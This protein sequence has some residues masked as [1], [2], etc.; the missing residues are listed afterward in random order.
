MNDACPLLLGMGDNLA[1][2]LV[3]DVAHPAPL[4]ALT[5]AH[6]ADLPGPLQ[7]L[8]SGIET[9]AAEPLGAAIAEEPRP[10]PHEMHHGRYLPA[11]VYSHDGLTPAGLCPSHPDPPLPTPPPPLT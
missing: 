10:L 7:A 8:A 9:A 11:Q 4:F 6:G 5:L 2:E 1:R 3:V